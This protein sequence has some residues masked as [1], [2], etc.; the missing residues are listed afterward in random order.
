MSIKVY[1]KLLEIEQKS[2][3]TKKFDVFL[4]EFRYSSIV[5]HTN[6]TNK[7]RKL[8]GNTKNTDPSWEAE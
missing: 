8:K 1:Q 5:I 7:I 4:I 2:R 3:Q 6:Q